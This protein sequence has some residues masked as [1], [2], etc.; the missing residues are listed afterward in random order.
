MAAILISA[1]P[2]ATALEAGREESMLGTRQGTGQGTMS[3]SSLRAGQWE[4]VPRLYRL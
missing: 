4:P 3:I 2:S 1:A